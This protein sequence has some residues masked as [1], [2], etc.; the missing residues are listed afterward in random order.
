MEK[1]FEEINEYTF[2]V[3]GSIRIEEVNEE[4]GF[5]LPPGD[6]ETIAGFVLG[7]LGHIPKVGEQ[8]RYENLKLVVTRMRGVKIAEILITREEH[9][10]AAR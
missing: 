7:L 2:R 8:T 5:G 1:D 9:A 3:D 6:Y 10:A 4:T